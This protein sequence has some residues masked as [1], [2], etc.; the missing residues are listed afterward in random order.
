MR[1][2][3]RAI[4]VHEDALLV[5]HR[6]K[7]GNEYDVLIGGGVN[8]GETLEQALFRELRE[9]GGVRITNP[10]LVFMEQAGDPYGMQYIFLCDYAGGQPALA[11]DSDEYAINALGQN[12]Y[13]PMWRKLGELP[14]VEF[15]SERLKQA[16]LHGLA[17]G[18][19]AEPLD[20]THWP[21]YTKI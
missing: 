16:I 9:E 10:R 19:P 13:Q 14:A 21:S 7:F 18:F 2:A 1:T 4:I 3:V 15:R 20:I 12:L 5:T 17:A 6:N 11:P 8:L